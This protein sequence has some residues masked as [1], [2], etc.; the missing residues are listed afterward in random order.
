MELVV[1]R[2]RQ[3]LESNVRCEPA[4]SRA[5]KQLARSTGW[6]LE[7]EKKSNEKQGAHCYLGRANLLEETSQG[8][9]NSASL[10]VF[11]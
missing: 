8:T 7:G 4:W 9:S 1:G 5:D 3:Q 10:M 11:K 6:V 2:S